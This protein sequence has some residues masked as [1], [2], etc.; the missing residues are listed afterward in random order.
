M[1]S[2]FFP[3]TTGIAGS[4]LSRSEFHHCDDDHSFHNNGKER[5][6]P[7]STRDIQN[8]LKELGFNLER[9]QLKWGRGRARLA[10]PDAESF[11][12]VL[13]GRRLGQPRPRPQL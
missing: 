3:E 9:N 4:I 2:H 5:A 11:W 8:R 10:Q 12:K 6:M 1:I 7:I 13:G